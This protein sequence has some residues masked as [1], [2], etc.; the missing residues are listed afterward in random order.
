MYL[1]DD[2]HV[3][4]GDWSPLRLA[5]EGLFILEG[6]GEP[7][8][9]NPAPLLCTVALVCAGVIDDPSPPPPWQASLGW[10]RYW[11]SLAPTSL[12]NDGWGRL[13][14]KLLSEPRLGDSEWMAALVMVHTWCRKMER[15]WDGQVY[16]VLEAAK[17]CHAHE[18]LELCRRLNPTHPLM[19]RV[20]TSLRW[21]WTGDYVSCLVQHNT[22][23]AIK[24]TN[25]VNGVETD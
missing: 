18:G 13:R 2:C 5:V 6:S 10:A 15:Q 8:L 4:T 9:P 19:Q 23:Q 3:E 22:W 21:F 11:Q 1:A 17:A 14:V 16:T 12:Q 25:A 24:K 20:D 7:D